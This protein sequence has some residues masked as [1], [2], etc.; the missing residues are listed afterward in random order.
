MGSRAGG[1]GRQGARREAQRVKQN[2]A[3]VKVCMNA[4]QKGEDKWKRVC[5]R[6]EVLLGWG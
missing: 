6:G 1:G 5:V 4:D 3:Y 2:V